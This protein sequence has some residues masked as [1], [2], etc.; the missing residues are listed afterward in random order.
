MLEE[1]VVTGAKRQGKLQKTPLAISHIGEQDISLHRV[2]DLRDVSNLVPGLELVTT[3]PQESVLVQLRGVGTTNITEIADGPVSVHVDGIYSPRSQGVASLLHDINRIEVLRGPQ[4]TLFGRNSSSG[5]INVYHKQPS[6]ESNTFDFELGAGSDSFR[7]TRVV[8]NWVVNDTLA[9]RASGAN[10]KRDA[11]TKVIDNYAGLGPQY[12]QLQDLEAFDQRLELDQ[13]GLEREDRYSWRLSALWKPLNQLDVALS[14]E[15]Y[16]DDGTGN[17]ELDP[18]LVER[19]LRAVVLDTEPFVDL[20]NE[21]LRARAEYRFNNGLTAVYHAGKAN[22]Q[23]QQ[24]HDTDHGRTGDFEI[25]RTV[26]SDFDFYSHEL[27]L[28]NDDASALQWIVGAFT[29]R[30][31]NSIVFAVDQQNRGG[32]RVP[33]LAPSWISGLA[34][35]AVSFA[36]QPERR[37]KSLGV[38]SQFNYNL[39]EKSSLSLGAR[40]N[41]DT[42]SDRGGRAINCRLPSDFGP[43]LDANSLGAFAPNIN[44]IYADPAASLAVSRGQFFDGGTAVGIA[45]QPCWIRQVNDNKVRWNNTSGLLRYDYELTPDTLFYGSV[46]TGFKAGHIQDAGNTADPETVVSYELGLKS[47]WLSNTL[48]I[49]SAL[50]QADYEDLQFSDDDRIDTN[51]DGIPDSGGSTI[52][53]NA[54]DAQVRGLEVEIEWLASERDRLQAA[55]T[56]TDARFNKFDIPDSVFGNLFNPFSDSIGRTAADNVDLSGNSPPRTPDWKVSASYEHDFLIGDGVL[57]LG[58]F[59]TFSDDYFLDIFNRGDLAADVFPSL[60]NGGQQLGV[61]KAYALFDLKLRYENPINRWAI[62]AYIKNLDDEAVKI[63]S[64]NFITENG[65]T[66]NYLPP[67]TYGITLKVAM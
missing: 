10:Q 46:A 57:T 11:F 59:A 63:S 3:G 2:R 52:V 15:S 18:S 20:R 1:V 32:A 65:F 44:Q 31:S 61:Q 28:K 45:D 23:R 64:G 27:H 4:G 62:E 9:L 30:E 58:G 60:P 34:G 40:Y 14:F 41:R 54:S 49:N 39:N 8:A 25:E 37:S 66:A 50:F 36:I 24:L 6:F 33:N 26:A 51:G 38:Y 47:Q 29:S 35:A 48:R 43:Y 16:Q 67:R 22:M 42:K 5:S 53:R 21:V 17:A 7:A 12:P 56:L 13:V 19:G 55:I